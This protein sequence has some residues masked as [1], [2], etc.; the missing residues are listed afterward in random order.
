MGEVIANECDFPADFAA[1]WSRAWAFA[2]LL[3][4]PE[5]EAIFRPI[6]GKAGGFTFVKYLDSGLDFFGNDLFRCSKGL[7]KA[8]IPCEHITGLEEFME[9]KHVVGHAKGIRDLVYQAKPR[10]YISDIARCGEV[11]YCLEVFGTGSYTLHGHSEPCKVH[12]LLAEYKL[13]WVQ[14]NAIF[15]TSV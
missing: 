13:V 12:F 7:L 6:R 10:S 8:L 5:V 1:A 11:A 4:H 2:V 9:W 15:S 3:K 14:G